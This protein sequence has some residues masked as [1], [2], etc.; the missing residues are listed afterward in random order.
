MEELKDYHL[1]LILESLR[2][3]VK[4][5]EVLRNSQYNPKFI[6]REFIVPSLIA[7]LSILNTYVEDTIEEARKE[8]IIKAH[9]EK[10][11]LEEYFGE[12]EYTYRHG[13]V[14]FKHIVCF[15]SPEFR[16][17]SNGKFFVLNMHDPYVKMIYEFNKLDGLLYRYRDSED[18]KNPAYTQY[19]PIKLEKKSQE[20]SFMKRKP[21]L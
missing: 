6:D 18:Y 8:N 14:Y 10:E 15:G 12:Y 7:D 13:N 9:E 4:H 1:A 3:A 5:L 21:L 19:D 16:K 2:S 17:S 11:A 20:E